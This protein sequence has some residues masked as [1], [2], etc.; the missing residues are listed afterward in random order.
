MSISKSGV[1]LPGHDMPKFHIK[2]HKA[3]GLEDAYIYQKYNF[4]MNC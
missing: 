3:T 2:L 1:C 4:Y